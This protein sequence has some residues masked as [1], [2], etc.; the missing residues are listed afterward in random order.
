VGISRPRIELDRFV[1]EL[2]RCVEVGDGAQMIALGGQS[3]RATVMDETEVGT[4]DVAR[5]DQ[6]AAG[7]NSLVA[8]SRR[9]N[10]LV[11]SGARGRESAGD[12]QG[13]NDQ[14]DA[15]HGAVTQKSG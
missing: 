4:L 5:A 1:E 8:L 2:D 12:Q 3:P 15:I 7:R 10:L 11:V 6:A 13:C 14:Q 9:A